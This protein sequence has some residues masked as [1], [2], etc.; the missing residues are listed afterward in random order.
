MIRTHI[1]L[2]II[3]LTTEMLQINYLFAC[4]VLQ[5]CQKIIALK[6]VP[7]VIQTIFFIRCIPIVS[8]VG[9]VLRAES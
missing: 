1:F 6:Y 7:Y 9:F 4:T 8:R 2:C 5:K 3:I